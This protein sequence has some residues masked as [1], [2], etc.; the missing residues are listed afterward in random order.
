MTAPPWGE[1]RRQLLT[2]VTLLTIGALVVVAAL[3]HPHR[4]TP[5][6]PH[7]RALVCADSG[8]GA[9]ACDSL[10]ARDSM[11]TSLRDSLRW[12][13]SLSIVMRKRYWKGLATP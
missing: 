11:I 10:R 12:R 5:A 2:R 3:L 1:P 9:P 7:G 13:D 8:I 4:P 6:S